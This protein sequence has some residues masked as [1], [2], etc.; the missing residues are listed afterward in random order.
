M[1]HRPL[2]A[3]AAAALVAATVAAAAPVGGAGAPGV[4]DPVLPL[5]GNGGYHVQHYGLRIGWTPSS[6]QLTGDAVLDAR[7]TQDLSSFDLDLS[8]LEVDGVRVDG[9][10]AEFDRTGQELR[11]RP[12][13]ALVRGRDFR[14]EVAYH[15]EPKRLTDA[16]GALDGWITT[17]PATGGGTAGAAFVAG[18]PVGAMTWFPC[19]DHPSDKAAYDVTVTVPDGWTAVGNGQLVDRTTTGGTAGHPKLTAFHWR[20]TDPMAPYLVTA[21]VDRFPLKKTLLPSGLPVWTA[22]DPS[23][24]RAAD[25]VLARLPEVLAFEEAR[26][27]PYPFDSA[28]AIVEHAPKVGYA[29]ETQTRPVYASAPD[30]DTLVHESAHQWFG[31]SVSLT[32]WQDIWLNEGFA[33]YAEWLWDAAHGGKSTA[34]RFAALYARPADDDLWAYPTAHPGIP[35]YL[36]GDPSYSRGAMVLEKLREAVGDDTFFRILKQWTRDHRHGHGTTAEFLALCAQA[37]GKDLDP[38]F[39]TWLYGDGK[40]AQP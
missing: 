17:G 31:D 30:I 37:S 5:A 19:D 22:V 33:T 7:T 27:G 38:V 10:P 34:Q 18:E 26:F 9:V 14:V 12:D 13:T 40:P 2:L 15:G 3:L 29:L 39:R 23:E 21:S 36:F 11:V 28:G 4:G 8:G 20:E 25:P 32:S 1:S 16:D 24:A 6:R 35:A